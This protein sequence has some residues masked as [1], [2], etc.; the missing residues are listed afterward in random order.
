MKKALAWTLVGGAVL[1]GAW[2]LQSGNTP[3]LTGGGDY[4]CSDFSTQ[5]EAQTFFESSGGPASDPHKLDPDKD[6]VACETLP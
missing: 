1:G 5:S 3:S 6:G 2:W 4:N